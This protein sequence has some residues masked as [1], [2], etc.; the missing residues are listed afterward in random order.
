MASLGIPESYEAFIYDSY[1]QTN[2]LTLPWSAIKWQ[3]VRSDISAAEVTIAQAD[4]GIE[5]T[6]PIGGLRAWS[7]TA[8]SCGTGRL[9]AGAALAANAM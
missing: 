2:L 3:R 7:L 8:T 1:A 5:C 9:W 6:S 4:K